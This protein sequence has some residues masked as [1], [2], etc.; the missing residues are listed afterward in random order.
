MTNRSVVVDLPWWAEEAERSAGILASDEERMRF[1]IDLARRNV[2]ENTGGPFGAAIFESVTGRLVAAG[3]NS[4]LRL[5]QS[6]LHAEMLAY[7]R[8][9]ARV[10]SYSLAAPGLPAH[11]LYT[12][13]EPCAM[14]LGAALWSGV[15]A[16]V[17]GATREDAIRLHFD[18]G[19]VFPES[20]DYLQ[21]RGI[22]V[23][24]GL[25]RDEAKEVLEEY[26]SRGGIIYNR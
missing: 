14:C 4:V 26:R 18:E 17:C 6:S 13:C 10:Q 9:Q 22:A 21:R 15:A 1:A 11:T 25:L 8:A 20:Y 24:R 3:V 2:R 16:L 5:S 7:M 23:I 12:S 19:P